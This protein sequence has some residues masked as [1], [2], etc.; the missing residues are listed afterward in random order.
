MSLKLPKFDFKDIFAP[1]V[2]FPVIYI[3]YFSFGSLKLTI[4]PSPSTKSIVLAFMGLIFYL[5]GSYVVLCFKNELRANKL[6]YY[7]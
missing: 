2:L 6:L 5:L 3:L 1:W 4:L 7:I